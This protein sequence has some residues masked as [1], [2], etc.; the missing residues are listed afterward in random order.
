MYRLNLLT[1]SLGEFV[2]GCIL[3]LC[4]VMGYVLQFEKYRMYDR[5]Q[6]LFILGLF[7]E[8]SCCTFTLNLLTISL[9]EF[10]LAACFVMLQLF[11]RNTTYMKEYNHYYYY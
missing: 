7:G 3:V 5:S 11:L 1:I 8:F 6:L 10:V 9:G 2:L 4:F